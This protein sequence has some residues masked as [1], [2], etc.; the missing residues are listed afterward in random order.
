MTPTAEFIDKVSTILTNVKGK[1]VPIEELQEKAIDLAALILK[2]AQKVQSGSEKAKQE[3]LA[4]MMKDSKGKIFAAAMTD[5]CFRSQNNW[6]VADQLCYLLKSLGFPKFLSLPRRLELKLFKTFGKMM[7]P[8][9]VPLIRRI[10]RTETST[11][12]LPGEKQ[13]LA[14][15]LAKR[16]KEGVRINLNRLGEAILGEDE[17]LQRLQLYLDDLANPQV[18]YI[19]VKISTL[20]S[21]INLLA[22][23]DTLDLLAERLRS[24][25]CAAQT[26]RYVRADGVAV[27]KFVNLDM[28]EYRDMHLT[29][30]LFCKVLSDP[31]FHSHSAG[32]V[33]QAYLP[34]A[35]LM[36][37][38][39]TAWALERVASGGAPIKIRIVKGA[40][41]AMERVES[42]LHNW[43]Q[44][45]YENKMDVDANYIRMME[46]GCMPARAK[47]VHLGIGSHNLF[48]LSLALLLRSQNNVE[49]YMC[50]EMLEGMADHLCRVMQAV[51]SDMLLYCPVAK[52]NEFQHAVTY[53]VRR[54]DENTGPEN[55][56]RCLFGLHVG[57]AEWKQQAQLFVN[58]C[59]ATQ[60][61][62]SQPR[63]RQ[64][65][66]RAPVRLDM[67]AAFD[68]EPDTDWSLPENVS[69][70]KQLLQN[71][72]KREPF[73]LPLVIGGQDIKKTTPH[74]VGSGK[75]P[76]SPER[77]LFK[78]SLANGLDIEAAL[79]CA[80]KAHL[81]WSKVT[82]SERSAI[83][84]RVAKGL[85]SQRE[86]LIGAMVANAGKSVAEA[87]GEISE[88]IDFAEYYRRNIEE[89]Y[90]LED[91]AWTPK[92]T[93]LVAPPWNFPC[94]IPCGGALAALAAGNCVLFKPAIESVLVG[95][96]LAKIF[97][98][99][100]VSREVLQ[101]VVCQDEPIGS[102][103]LKDPRV[104]AVILTGATS[105]AKQFMQMRQGLDLIA[106]TGGKNAIIVTS[107]ADRDLAIKALISSAFG[108]A[109]QKCSACSLAILE[110]EVYDDPHFLEQLK[111]AAQSLPVGSAWDLNAY[112]TPLIAAPQPGSV[113]HSALTQLEVGQE[114]LL[115]PKPHPQ[116][117]QLWSPGIKLGVKA[118]SFTHQTEFFGPLLGVMRAESLD[119]AIMLANGSPYGLTSG[120]HSLDPREHRLWMEKIEAGNCYINRGITGAIV[121]RQ[122]FGGCKES[123]FGSGFKAGGP[124]Y[125]IALMHAKQQ[126]IPKQK[127]KPTA[128]IEKL[129]SLL[130]EVNNFSRDEK[131]QWEASIGS[132][133][134]YWDCYFSK[135]HDPSS[136]L[137]QDNLL[138]YRPHK[139][140]TLRLNCS[141]ALLDIMRA[142]AAAVT[143]GSS[144]EISG[145]FKQLE[146]LM[147]LSQEHE[148]K[149]NLIAESEL[150][151]QERLSMQ[152]LERI[153]MFS[154]PSLQ[155][156]EAF[157]KGGCKVKICPV[158]ANG[159]IE[160][161][162]FLQ[163]VVF[164]IDYHRNGNLGAREKDKRRELPK[165]HY[166]NVSVET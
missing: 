103:L 68:N 105:T 23:D 64:N 149:L 145:E 116:N 37:Q 155:L 12:I 91:I 82:P 39:L 40:N 114:W 31:Q 136:L 22:I 18:E 36:Q 45:P 101:F 117:P 97:W 140:L 83:L 86:E 153:R 104:A 137:G 115:R 84:A 69:W 163:E 70:A 148:L 49:P 6:R 121:Q 133:A 33:L 65:R 52:K 78:Y 109:G 132:Y 47:A 157:A 85:R 60:T 150:E 100:G 61:I 20:T 71:W 76:S 160:L 55:F 128:S 162:N 87:D 127:G 161:L 56:L 17:A 75:D 34:D 66:L 7:A 89:L 50:F 143:V 151:F 1:I 59:K 58:S 46:Y 94:S 54:L 107:L 106:E 141:D 67:Y 26:Q 130:L 119:E 42:A 99:A 19:S 98:E 48:D 135:Q 15:H 138:C 156:S 8:L 92:G 93:L 123:S 96:L 27:P 72:K 122:P 53:L 158:I 142:L 44:A 57:S 110:A 165:P 131:L 118:Q 88:A 139:K 164:S 90:C 21:Q 166:A 24:L 32:I 81:S 108:H 43:P 62:S 111:D 125:L 5:Q 38:K 30:E 152:K 95:Y 112:V 147:L 120:L 25:Y 74:E 51:A 124:N 129:T 113:L 16:R 14:A 80:E 73:H 77:E 35:F 13:A 3:Q 2:E 134:F 126:D 9:L 144:L 41:L 102:K 146:Q 10:L 63:R 29:V 28:E 154:S 159:R 79:Q 4:R 11:V